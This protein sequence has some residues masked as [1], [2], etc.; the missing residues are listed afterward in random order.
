M[1]LD[2]TKEGEESMWCKPAPE[3]SYFEKAILEIQGEELLIG[4]GGNIGVEKSNKKGDH[5]NVWYASII[6]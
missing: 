3:R 1:L 4:P 5:N 2:P 6:F